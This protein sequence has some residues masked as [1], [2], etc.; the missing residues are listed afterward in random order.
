M[1]AERN[2]VHS[3]PPSSL[4]WWSP[5]LVSGE[6]TIVQVDLSADAAREKFAVGWLDEAEF[7]RCQRYLAEPRRQFVLCRAALRVILC[8]ELGC[9]NGELSFRE[10]EHGKPFAEVNGRPAALSFSVSHSGQYGLI[11]HAPRGRLGVD[12]EQLVPK[13]HLNSLIHAVMGP[14]E[15]RELGEMA[16]PARLHQFFR[17]WTCKEA[18]VKALGT[19]FSTD[20]SSFQAPPNIRQGEVEGVFRFPHLPEPAWRLQDIS[21]EGFVAALA[22]ELP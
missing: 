1:T 13:R 16:E 14:D 3:A 6:I 11:A 17:L 9:R 21:G 7:L 12:V 15:Q 20:I 2:V 5:L 10:G 22:W 18:L 4:L 8:E 19:G